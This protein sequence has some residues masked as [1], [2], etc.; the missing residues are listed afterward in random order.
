MPSVIGI[1]EGEFGNAVFMDLNSVEVACMVAADF[2][3]ALISALTMWLLSAKRP[4]AI[5]VGIE[6]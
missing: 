5:V 1:R 4:G 3:A 6:C 2:I